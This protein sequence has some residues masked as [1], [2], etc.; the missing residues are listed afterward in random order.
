MKRSTIL[1]VSAAAFLSSAM[2]SLNP[3]VAQTAK[4]L[5]GAWAV[6]SVDNISV[7]G[8]RTPAFGAEPRR[9]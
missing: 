1:I 9:A 2:S 5:V 7:E 8:R 4:D 6:V 3:S